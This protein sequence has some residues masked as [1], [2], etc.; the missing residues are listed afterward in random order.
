M[1]KMRC[2]AA[3]VVGGL[4]SGKQ[5]SCDYR[6]VAGQGGQSLQIRDD[7]V[8]KHQFILRLPVHTMTSVP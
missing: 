2:Q 4:V 5:N 7:V 6:P 3:T 1:D 8:K